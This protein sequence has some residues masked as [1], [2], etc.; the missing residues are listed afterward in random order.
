MSETYSNSRAY[1][2]PVDELLEEVGRIVYG[3]EQPISASDQKSILRTLNLSLLDMQSNIQPIHVVQTNTLET[4]AGTSEYALSSDILDFYGESAMI[5]NT[6]MSTVDQS[7]SRLS[8]MD[9]LMIPKKDVSGRPVQFAIERYRDALHLKLWPV[10]D[11]NYTFTYKANYKLQDVTQ[12]YQLLDIP[13][14]FYPYLT[15]KVAYDYSYRNPKF[16]ENKRQSLKADL[17]ELRQNLAE[18]DAEKVSIR[19][20]P[21]INAWSG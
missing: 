19:F 10:P 5:R 2:Y 16:D 6:D 13:P 12:A 1:Y 11:D 21:D 3:S 14:R 17:A 18:E 8:A 7:I 20:V 9:F 15:K 4:V